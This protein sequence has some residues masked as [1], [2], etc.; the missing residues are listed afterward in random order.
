[1]AGATLATLDAVTKEVYEGSLREQLN[2]EVKILR[3]IEKTS[4]GTTNEVGGRY[5][6]FPIHTRRNTGIGARSEGGTLPTPGNQGTAAARVGLKY[7]YGGVRLTG[8]AISLIDTNYQSF[9]SAMDLEIDGLRTDLAIDLNRQVFGDGT[10]TLGT[11]TANTSSANTITVDRVDL[12]QLGMIVDV[13]TGSTVDTA[14]REVTAINST[15]K[16]VTLSGATFSAAIGDIAVRTGN[17]GL[18]WTGLD[19]I[20][21]A[22]GSLFN[23]NPSTEPVWKSTVDHNSGT[24]RAISENRLTTM[25]DAIS[26]EG[27][28]TTVIWTTKGVRRAYANL[29]KT[30]QQFVNTTKFEGGFSGIA[31]TTDDGDIPI[32]TDKMAPPGTLTFLNE[33]E[34]KL[35][36]AFDWSWMDRD[37]SKWERVQDVDAWQAR[38][39]QYS[40]IGTH[41]RNSHGR[42][43]DITEA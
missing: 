23:I 41:R 3:R 31:F 10:G 42:I 36:R 22:S 13:C 5:V 40:E 28:K 11:L 30:T 26:D 20:I 7:Q 16:V 39:H 6:T 14:A 27:G 12:F 25:A 34:I 43:E 15:T 1:M 33:K 24:P 21:A 8:Q 29:L 38:L 2:N 35:Y 17:N 9:I 32:L 18:E 37:G 4:D 19:K